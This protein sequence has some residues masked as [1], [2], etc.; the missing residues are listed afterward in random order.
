MQRSSGS[1]T[2]QFW[3]LCGIYKPVSFSWHQLGIK[4]ALAPRP[5]MTLNASKKSGA[6]PIPTF[7]CPHFSW[8]Q[9]DVFINK[10]TSCSPQRWKTGFFELLLWLMFK[11]DSNEPILKTGEFN[12]NKLFVLHEKFLNIKQ[13]YRKIQ[14]FCWRPR[15]FQRPSL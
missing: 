1:C 10:E 6:L 8:Q 9:H 11:V 15:G 4:G 13:M 5:C 14:D 2:E 12:F 7:L 3:F